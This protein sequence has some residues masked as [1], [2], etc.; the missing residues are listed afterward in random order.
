MENL[1]TVEKGDLRLFVDNSKNTIV[2]LDV[3]LQCNR[4]ITSCIKLINTN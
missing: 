2:I 4:F 1:L 3:T